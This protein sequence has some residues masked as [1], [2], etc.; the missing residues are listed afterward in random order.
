MSLLLERLA[1]AAHSR[2]GV[3]DD[4]AGLDQRH[5]RLQREDRRGRI[6]AGRRHRRR[7]GD[8]SPVEL[9]N[10]VDEPVEK[11]RRRRA[12][13]GT[14]ARS[15]RRESSRKSAP[16]STKGM[17]RAM[18]SRRD[19]LRLAVGQGGEDQVDAVQRLGCITIHDRVRDRPARDGGGRGS[20]ACARPAAAEQLRRAQMRMLGAE[21]EKLRADKARGS[22]DG[23]ANHGA[24]HMA[25]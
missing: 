20:S 17:P 1:G 3:D 12:A 21:P 25:R 18:M 16:R 8:R 2:G 23:D 5:Q 13:R 4:A 19:R 14:S 24:P 9:R 6:A 15:P 11:L 10:A 7:T 22:K